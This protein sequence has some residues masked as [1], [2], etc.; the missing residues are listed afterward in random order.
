[1]N[2]FL[3]FPAT[4]TISTTGGNPATSQA[5]LDSRFQSMLH[6]YTQQRF[7]T[8]DIYYSLAKSMIDEGIV[9]SQTNRISLHQTAARMKIDQVH[10]SPQNSAQQVTDLIAMASEY[11]FLQPE[12]FEGLFTSRLFPDNPLQMAQKIW[13]TLR[14]Q[15]QKTPQRRVITK[16]LLHN[17]EKQAGG[18]WV[19]NQAFKI[20]KY[21]TR[22]TWG[23][24]TDATKYLSESCPEKLGDFLKEH[25][26]ESYT[27]QRCFHIYRTV[28]TERPQVLLA[29]QQHYK[30]QVS[31]A[32]LA[33]QGHLA[34]DEQKHRWQ[35]L[36]RYLSLLDE[37]PTS[38]RMS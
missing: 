20:L 1:M 28:L 24:L 18:D 4:H 13:S 31:L 12:V 16:D 2:V 23:E 19:Q 21:S 34:T 3:T 27:S 10:R 22:Y 35:A 15:K 5:Q 26:R 14:T 11:L 25:V 29:H 37:S 6:Q 7:D 30:N 33:T 32:L 38:P 9:T 8:G 17:L 36:V